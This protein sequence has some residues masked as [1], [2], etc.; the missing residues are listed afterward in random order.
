MISG[1]WPG[2]IPHLESGVSPEHRKP[3]PK[4]PTHTHTNVEKMIPVLSF[5][6]GLVRSEQTEK[7]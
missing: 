2:I 1:A 7:F 4:I 6:V 5:I 3:W